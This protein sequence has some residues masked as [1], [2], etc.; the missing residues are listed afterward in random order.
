MIVE[1]LAIGYAN[2]LML[3]NSLIKI[4]T[5]ATC[6]LQQI[7]V[8]FKSDLCSI[9]R[10]QI[11]WTHCTSINSEQDKLIYIYNKYY[12]WA[13]GFAL[14]PDSNIIC[15]YIRHSRVIVLI[16]FYIIYIL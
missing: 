9:P 7:K 11:P 10:F 13:L 12:Y 3:I 5:A 16:Y 6:K 4:Y 8:A 15:N 14:K 1:F 2:K